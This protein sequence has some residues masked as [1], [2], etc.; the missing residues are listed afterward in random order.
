MAPTP[1]ATPA[2]K[3]KKRAKLQN[4]RVIKAEITDPSFDKYRRLNI[5]E[6][7]KSREF[8]VRSFER[9][10][11]KV[12]ASQVARVFQNLPRCLRR[13][14]ASHNVK[15]IPKRLRNRA[16][17]EML[18]AA[19][20]DKPKASS[21]G[22]LLH[23]YKMR[24]R[25]LKLGAKLKLLRQLPPYINR[26]GR[27]LGL[28]YQIRQLNRDIA[29]FEKNRLRKY[30]NKCGAYDNYG[31]NEL[32]NRPRG[33][34]SYMHRQK[35]FVWLPTHVWHA[36]RFHMVANNG[37]KIPLKPLQKCY[38]STHRNAKHKC[39]AMETS[40]NDVLLVKN[41]EPLEFFLRHT[42]YTKAVPPSLLE[43]K[44]SYVGPLYIND[45]L[46]TLGIVFVNRGKVMVR[47]HAQDYD[48]IFRWLG[49]S[50]VLE[51]CRY[52]IGSIDVI[53]PSALTELSKIL[54]L[55]NNNLHWDSVCSL[56][57]HR[58][59]A[60]GTTYTFDIH[61]P[62]LWKQPLTKPSPAK[63]SDAAKVI[64][65]NTE[66]H[67]DLSQLFTTHGRSKS[68]ENM[69]PV[70]EL[71][72][73]FREAGSMS[74]S[75]SQEVITKSSIPVVVIKTMVGWT[76]LVP[77]YWVLPVWIKLV[78]LPKVHPGGYQQLYQINFENYRPTYPYDFPWL[79]AG[80]KY[81]F[82]NGWLLKSKYQLREKKY[83]RDSHEDYAD[84]EFMN[85]FECDWSCLRALVFIKQ[86]YKLTPQKL[87]EG[88]NPNFQYDKGDIKIA[89]YKDLRVAVKR[90]VVKQGPIRCTTTTVKDLPVVETFGDIRKT[91]LPIKLIG[92]TC[93]EGTISDRARLFVGDDRDLCDVVGFVTS[94]NFNLNL[95]HALGLAY[96]A[97][98]TD[99]TNLF[100]RN[101]GCSKFYLVTARYLDMY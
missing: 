81:N 63:E 10:Q 76:V 18:K 13:R 66:N 11:L 98:N 70:K 75:V 6:F 67:V 25:L 57:D 52:A 78:R 41:A 19:K 30:N 80:T 24:K 31:F 9:A 42:K 95:G 54:H 46:T 40:Y 7:I 96:I 64:K 93:D 15:R 29:T 92:I 45:R 86:L 50:Y 62:R 68:Y 100:V 20:G 51:D 1:A 79:T 99:I 53:G 61:D 12:K 59:I 17:N 4:S 89:D 82:A 91:P 87:R 71:N 60:V 2:N 101:V 16:L 49:K 77:W 37:Y 97:A 26:Y 36:K 88:A 34:F 90:S 5:P 84:P 47:V 35:E 21:R 94:G 85:P 23:M 65:A 22:R 43:G 8:E 14:T 32:A 33:S 27:K 72:K 55:V 73:K 74:N 56:T 44:R 83:S 58:D 39:V 48:Y 28:R 38:R 69:L 3:A